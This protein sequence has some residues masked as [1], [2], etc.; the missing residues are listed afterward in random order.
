MHPAPKYSAFELELLPSSRTTLTILHTDT[1]RTATQSMSTSLPPTNYGSA[2]RELTMLLFDSFLPDSKACHACDDV[3]MKYVVY[4]YRM[5]LCVEEE[6]DNPAPDSQEHRLSLVV[7]LSGKDAVRASC[8]FL[9]IVI[10]TP[11]YSGNFLL[12]DTPFRPTCCS[13]CAGTP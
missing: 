12:R 7:D 6:S 1:V 5:R 2:R 13:E 11:Q 10:L 4:E 9:S 3:E 8:P